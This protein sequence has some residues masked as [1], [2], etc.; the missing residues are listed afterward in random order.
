MRLPENPTHLVK[1]TYKVLKNTNEC[2]LYKNPIPKDFTP[3]DIII[4]LYM[5]V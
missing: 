3:L 1:F 5:Y 4:L 2:W